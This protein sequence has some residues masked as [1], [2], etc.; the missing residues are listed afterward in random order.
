[1]S[2]EDEAR[3]RAL[4]AYVEAFVVTAEAAVRNQE[5][6]GHGGQHVSFH[7]DFAC[8]Q[9]SVTARLRW[10][11]AEGREALAGLSEVASHVRNEALEEAAARADE[12]PSAGLLASDIR[13]MKR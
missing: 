13:A 12:Y 1:M 8:I 4:A 6:K 3:Y 10:W 5:T 7:G 9:P 11:A 2:P